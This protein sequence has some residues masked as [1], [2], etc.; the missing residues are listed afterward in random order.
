MNNEKDMMYI[1]TL[2]KKS[3]SIM[4]L[5]EIAAVWLQRLPYSLY[6]SAASKI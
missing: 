6:S 3:Y 2:L 4:I 1:H 5:A